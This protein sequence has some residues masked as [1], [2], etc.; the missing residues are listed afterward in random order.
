MPALR[1]S[2]REE[3]RTASHCVL[4]VEVR[5]VD[6]VL[7]VEVTTRDDFTAYFQSR[8]W[9][10]HCVL[11]VKPL[12]ASGLHCVLPVEKAAPHCVL[13]VEVQPN[14]DLTA[15]FRSKKPH[16][17]AYLRSMF[18]I[19]ITSLRTSD[20]QMKGLTTCFQ[21]RF[22]PD[23]PPLRTSSRPDGHPGPLRTSSRALRASGPSTACFRSVHCVLPVHRGFVKL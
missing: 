12:T 6:C 21:S 8:F 4:S 14:T 13:R 20:R 17:T 3:H 1:T 7:S 2:S 22:E 19:G 5:R 18:P 16:R 11:S 15:Y 10:L 23:T 9:Q